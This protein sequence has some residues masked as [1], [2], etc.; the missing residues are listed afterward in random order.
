M[1]ATNWEQ[2]MQ[3]SNGIICIQSIHFMVT[4][5]PSVWHL[6]FVLPILFFLTYFFWWR[7]KKQK[8][9]KLK[10]MIEKNVCVFLF[11]FRFRL[12]D[13]F[14]WI[15]I[16]M[17]KIFVKRFHFSDTTLMFTCEKNWGNKDA[18][19]CDIWMK[20]IAYNNTGKRVIWRRRESHAIY[21]YIL[22]W[23][24]TLKISELR[25]STGFII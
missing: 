24:R 25:P 22:N 15:C 5:F 18:V 3:N 4:N 1:H 6:A 11:L 20:N 14:S 12:V 19:L 7:P 16:E 9:F 10:D 21:I 8:I 2:H 17:K 23:N 13:H